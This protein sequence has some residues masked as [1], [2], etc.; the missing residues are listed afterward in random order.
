MAKTSDLANMTFGRWTVLEKIGKD[1]SGSTMWLCKCSCGTT[2]AVRH[3]S[4]TSGNSKSCGCLHAE[5]TSATHIK[6][7][8][9]GERL[10]FVWNT[11]KQRCYNPNNQKYADYGGRGIKVCEEWK[12]SYQAFREWAINS[13]YDEDAGVNECTI[14]RIDVNGDYSPDN[15]RW[16]DAK[17]Q[18]NNVRRHGN[19][20]TGSNA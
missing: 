1:S 3:S 9:Y 16:A 18:A 2:R 6:H 12:T 20:Y 13:G 7:G 11:M 17:I 19:Q 8:H 10:Y 14:D 5:I 4:L 15:C